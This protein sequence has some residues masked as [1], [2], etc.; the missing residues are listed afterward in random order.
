MSK[1]D[2]V[3]TATLTQAREHLAAAEAALRGATLA[4]T[5]EQE[6]AAALALAEIAAATKLLKPIAKAQGPRPPRKHRVAGRS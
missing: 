5:A 6:G 1:S 2:R 4:D 3:H